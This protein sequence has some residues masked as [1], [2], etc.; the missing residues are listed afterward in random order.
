MSNDLISRKALI[1]GF[2][3]FTNGGKQRYL[4]SEEIWEMVELAPTAYNPD[5]VVEQLK[6][7]S[8]GTVL[9]DKAEGV[10]E[11]KTHEIK[12]LPLY[13]MAVIDGKKNFE[14]RKDDRGY[15]VGD[16]VMLKEWTG[17][18]YTGR[19]FGTKIK[20]VLRGCPEYGLMEGYCIFGW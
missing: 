12:I 6:Q 18:S 8:V 3:E 20:Y 14:L 19:E 11:M 15:Q 7:L 17:K 4:I 5:K 9:C 13:F 16:V 2:W 10:G 1:Q